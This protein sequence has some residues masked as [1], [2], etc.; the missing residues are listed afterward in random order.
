MWCCSCASTKGFLDAI[1][2]FHET[3][4][5]SGG[6]SNAGSS[7]TRSNTP[8]TPDIF[9]DSTFLGHEVVVVKN[10]LRVCGTGGALG[11]Q[12]LIQ[13]KSYF[14]VK[15]QQDGVWGM[16]V[17]TRN[18]LLEN[19]PFG[20]DTES[21]IMRQ[22]GEFFHNKMKIGKIESKFQ[23]GDIF[24]RVNVLIRC[25]TNYNKLFSVQGIS[26]DHIELSFYINGIKSNI[27]FSNVRG[28]VFPALFGEDF[29]FIMYLKLEI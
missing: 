12:P 27:S 6:S 25:I 1:L 20:N 14:E 22:T 3:E 13:T 15:L 7:R 17:A 4:A 28:T 9:I 11:S 5:V 8:K 18:T 19:G 23:E 26:Y 21:W 10:G 24:V 16:G 2:G 29:Q